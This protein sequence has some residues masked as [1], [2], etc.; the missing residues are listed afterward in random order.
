MEVRLAG[1]DDAQIISELNND[2]QRIHAEALPDLFKQ[3][4][5]ET[6]PVSVIVD[7]ISNPENYFFIAQVDG[8]AVGYIYAEIRNLPGNVWRYATSQ[9][10]IHH[11]SVQPRHQHKG[12][13]EKLIQAVK[14][15]ARDKSIKT[16]ALDVWSFNTRAHVFF[17]KQ[18]FTNYNERMWLEIE[19]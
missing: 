18:G 11:I 1:V 5:D 10:Y 4:S 14:S 13:G 2:V 6:F 17:A 19:S 8:E 12:C 9:V 3:P 7:L 16:V 15:L